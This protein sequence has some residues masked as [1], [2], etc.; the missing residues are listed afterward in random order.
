MESKEKKPILEDK[1]PAEKSSDDE[2]RIND[3]DLK[4][5]LKHKWFWYVLSGLLLIFLS[6]L[7]YQNIQAAKNGSL[8]ILE[9]KKF[10]IFNTVKNFLFHS[11]NMLEGQKIGRASCRE[12][13]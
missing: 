9:P 7:T 1:Y 13:V 5:P 3:F 11:D 10:G 8:Q 2:K 6:F 4:K 12:R